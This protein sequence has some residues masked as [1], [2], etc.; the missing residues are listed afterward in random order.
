VRKVMSRSEPDRFESVPDLLILDGEGRC[1]YGRHLLADIVAGRGSRRV[2]KVIGIAA[3]VLV[4]YMAYEFR[5]VSKCREALKLL[6]A[7]S[8]DYD[9]LARISEKVKLTFDDLEQI[10]ELH[11]RGKLYHNPI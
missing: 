11:F 8:I 7:G 3:E 5:E 9:L 10:R 4:V 2:Y 1:I 6:E